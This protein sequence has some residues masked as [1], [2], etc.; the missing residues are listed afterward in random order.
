MQNMNTIRLIIITVPPTDVAER[1]QATRVPVCQQYNALWSLN[2]PPHVTLRTGVRVPEERMDEFLDEFGVLLEGWSAFPIRTDGVSYSTMEYEG[3]RKFFI[4]H[5]VIKDESLAT[6]NRRLLS[7]TPY[8]K[9]EK[10]HF[11]PHVTLLWD[12]L[13]KQEQ[14]EVIALAEQAE[15]F[16]HSY[17]WTCDNVSLY[18]QD[19]SQWIPFHIYPLQ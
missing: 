11:H 5:P 14:E 17:E 10:T 3:E 16:E 7:Y 8:R 18:V 15:H 12:T 19:G 13:E 1:I 6:F 2:Y 9:N 4:Y